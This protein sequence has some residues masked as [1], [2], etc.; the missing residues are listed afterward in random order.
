M[1]GTEPRGQASPFRKSKSAERLN[2]MNVHV[3][4]VRL[5][6]LFAAWHP[7]NHLYHPKANYKFCLGRRR[8]AE[9]EPFEMYEMIA[10]WLTFFYVNLLR[11]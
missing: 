3:H 11:R 6:S 9:R 7:G 8:T 2:G 5:V 1:P 10:V 4:R